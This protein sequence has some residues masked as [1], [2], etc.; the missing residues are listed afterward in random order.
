MTAYIGLIEIG[1]PRK[2]ETVVVSTAAGSVG[3]IVVQIAKEMGCY[4]VGIAGEDDKCDYVTKTLG[5]DKCINYKKFLH[6]EKLFTDEIKSHTPKGIDVYFD[7]V[8]GRTLDCVLN[9]INEGA[10]IVACGAISTYNYAAN[11]KSIPPEMKVKNYPKLIIKNA[12]ITG[13]LYFDHKEALVTGREYL[14]NLLKQG[15]L[16]Y[17]EDV[18]TGIENYPEAFKKLFTGKNKGK[19]MIKIQSEAPRPKL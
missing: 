10:R 14:I 7:N 5:A 3:E 18:S 8:G 17:N 9:H 16:K 13:F 6:D 11:A 12:S 2:G 1:K 19:T 15:K 4:V